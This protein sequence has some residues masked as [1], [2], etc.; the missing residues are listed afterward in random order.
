MLMIFCIRKS[1]AV[2][3]M[4]VTCKS[5]LNFQETASTTV[6]LSVQRTSYRRRSW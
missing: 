3:F 1:D 2:C 6:P 5:E 4:P